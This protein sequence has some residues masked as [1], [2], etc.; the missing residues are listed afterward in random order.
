MPA[1]YTFRCFGS[2]SLLMATSSSPEARFIFYCFPFSSARQSAQQ[3]IGF[4]W[5]RCANNN[6]NNR[7]PVD[8]CLLALDADRSQEYQTLAKIS[9]LGCFVNNALDHSEHQSSGKSNNVYV[10]RAATS[11]RSNLFLK[12]ATLQTPI[13]QLQLVVWQPV[14]AVEAVLNRQHLFRFS[15]PQAMWFLINVVVIRAKSRQKFRLQRIWKL[16]K[17]LKPLLV[18]HP[19][20]KRFESDSWILK[21]EKYGVHE[22]QYCF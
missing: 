1:C 12:R 17:L 10:Y 13:E 6:N 21:V 19:L 16:R 5:V 20:A 14:A 9:H 3:T 11:S 8:D 15:L 4:L 7:L 22:R 2:S 18:V